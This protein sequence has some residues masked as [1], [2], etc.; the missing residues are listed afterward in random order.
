[1]DKLIFLDI[2]GVL[3]S[4]DFH[5]K[6]K[7]LIDTDKI[8]KL[9]QLEGKDVKIVISSSWGYDDGKTEQSLR[10]CG[11]TLPIVGYT[12]HLHFKY[13]WACRGNEIAQ[14][15]IEHYNDTLTPFGYQTV[16]T[17][18]Y[19]ILDDDTDMLL[20]QKE[21]FVHVDGMHG[22]TD[23]DIAKVCNILKIS[24]D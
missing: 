9:N 10:S 5:R 13:S 17:Y 4:P 23:E 20:G 6:N 8:K 24:N 21:H 11:L 18:S 14:Y 16:D 19:A 7:C 12:K 15:I 1:M 22:L 3:N 2:D